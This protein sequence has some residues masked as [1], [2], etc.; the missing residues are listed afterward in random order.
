[1]T[2]PAPESPEPSGPLERL[3]AVQAEDTVGEQLRH[4]R[5]NLP[6][7]AALDG[8]AEMVAEVEAGRVD[9]EA[10]QSELTRSQKRLEDEV[11][12][13][14]ARITEVTHLLH[15]G[16]VTVPRELQALQHE[17]ESLRR[18]QDHLETEELE[19]LEELDPLN[20]EL[21]A[22]SDQLGHLETDAEK[23]QRALREAEAGIEEEL[24]Q[25]IARRATAVAGVPADLLETY[26]R[27]RPR[28]GGVAVAKLSGGVCGG[29]HLGLSAVE[30]DRIKRQP[31]DALVYCEE[32]GRLLVR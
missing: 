9:R 6:E 24:T 14:E 7:R 28:L 5:D 2:D 13:L 17:Q 4:R 8:H 1:M 20:E 26:D 22:I 16:A 27:L 12:S 29:C 15:S 32:C 3:L 10:R 21:A 18:R 19:I 25:V 23:L 31:P 11:A 30:V